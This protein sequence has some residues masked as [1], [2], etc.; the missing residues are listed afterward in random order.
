[1]IDRLVAMGKIIVARR[2]LHPI[3]LRSVVA[4]LLFTLLL[5]PRFSRVFLGRGSG[6]GSHF[7]SLP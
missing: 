5:P 1:M 3:F 4:Y 7:A 2:I 6:L